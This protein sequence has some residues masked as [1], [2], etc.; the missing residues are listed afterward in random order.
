MP[1]CYC[2][3]MP[4]HAMPSSS[5]RH[6]IL[7]LPSHAPRVCR[8]SPEHQLAPAADSVSR[9]RA[10]G[11]GWSVHLARPPLA[12]CLPVCLSVCLWW[13]APASGALRA[14]CASLALPASLHHPRTRTRASLQFTS[15]STLSLDPPSDT[16]AHNPRPLHAH[17]APP[18]L[19][20]PL[21]LTSLSLPLTHTTSLRRPSAHTP[22]PLSMLQRHAHPSLC[23]DVTRRHLYPL[24]S[25]AL[26]SSS[27]RS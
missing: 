14:P 20:A 11:P 13:S 5:S 6:A 4:C 19:R 15:P 3:A 22:S 9:A 24:A 10:M 26:L 25:A 12:V 2:H 23:H 18:S 17:L 7:L 8:V 16:H 1:A 21:T 27:S